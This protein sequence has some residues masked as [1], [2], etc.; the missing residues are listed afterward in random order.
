MVLRSWTA[1]SMT[2][3]HPEHSPTPVMP[4]SVSILTKSQLRKSPDAADLA[5]CDQV[6]SEAQC[7]GSG[8]P[9]CMRKV[10][11][12]VI[13]MILPLVGQTL[14]ATRSAALIDGAAG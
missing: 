14:T 13:F 8:A 4:S 10:R 6:V 12:P 3:G 1:V 2:R 11:M 7:F 5:G 9:A